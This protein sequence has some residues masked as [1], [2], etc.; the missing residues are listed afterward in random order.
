MLTK[1]EAASLI[2]S[3]Q[4]LGRK[5]SDKVCLGT[6]DL[7]LTASALPLPF[8]ALPSGTTSADVGGVIIKVKKIGAPT[9]STY[10]LRYTQSVGSTPTTSVG[11]WMGDGDLFEINNNT[12]VKALKLISTDALFCT[13]TIEYYGK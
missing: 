13:I 7:T 6:E 10:L 11:M 4:E 1:Q 3:M 9:D 8:T 12:N 2:G 5:L